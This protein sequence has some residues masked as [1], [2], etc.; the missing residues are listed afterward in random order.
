[1]EFRKKSYWIQSENTDNVK[2][3]INNMRKVQSE[4]RRKY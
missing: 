2:K 1:M 3:F 4:H